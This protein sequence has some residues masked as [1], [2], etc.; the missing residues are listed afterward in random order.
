LF[1]CDRVFTNVEWLRDCDFVV[2]S[3]FFG[4][5]RERARANEH[6]FHAHAVTKIERQSPNRLCDVCRSGA[7]NH[8]EYRKSQTQSTAKDFHGI[9]SSANTSD[10]WFNPEGESFLEAPTTSSAVLT[11][12]AP[13]GRG[14]RDRESKAEID[15]PHFF[16]QAEAISSR[17][18]TLYCQSVSMPAEDLG[19]T[20]T[21]RA[22]AAQKPE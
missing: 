8:C 21:R 11:P 17:T 14:R 2:G 12:A 10:N 22:A 20:R 13:P 18:T 3:I 1:L 9:L 4:P 5:H 6:D 7:N 19:R 16:F 15:K